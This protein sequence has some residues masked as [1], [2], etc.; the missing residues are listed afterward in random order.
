MNSMKRKIGFWGA[1]LLLPL[2]IPNQALAAKSFHSQQH[3]VHLYVS[4]A[5]HGKKGIGPETL[6]KPCSIRMSSGFATMVEPWYE[7][8]KS[9]STYDGDR[10]GGV[11]YRYFVGGEKVVNGVL[12]PTLLC[13]P[14]MDPACED[15]RHLDGADA[16]MV[17]VHGSNNGDHWVGLLPQEARAADG[18]RLGCRIHAPEGSPTSSPARATMLPGRTLQF[19]HLTSC[20]SM[21]AGNMASVERMF[22]QRNGTQAPNRLKAVTGFHGAGAIWDRLIGQYQSLAR[23]GA[24]EG[25]IAAWQ[26]ELYRKITYAEGDRDQ[27]PTSYGR[28]KA[29]EP[30]EQCANRLWRATYFDNNPAAGE[31]GQETSRAMFGEPGCS[32]PL[33]E[34]FEFPE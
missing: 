6:A 4:D 7:T 28:C 25:V 8:M 27:C 1:L 23:R 22:E 14:S 9:L 19:L 16:A 17:A 24:S 34:P 12:D 29:G 26:T 21:D 3:R 2:A 10:G 30:F 13:D 15:Y 18:S 32:P 31:D 5:R 20:N 33:A 11:A